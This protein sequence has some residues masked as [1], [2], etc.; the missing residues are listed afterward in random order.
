M[1][2]EEHKNLIDL[3]LASGGDAKKIQ[4]YQSFS[5]ANFV[6][7]KYFVKQLKVELPENTKLST[8]PTKLSTPHPE[9][10]APVKERKGI[11]NDLISQ[12]PV[13][14]HQE[15]QNRYKY[16]LEA[17]SLKVELN[18]VHY[19]DEKTAYEIQEKIMFCFEKMDKAQK[20][21][22]HYQKNKRIL[23]TETKVDFSGLSPM[24]L[25]N[26]RNVTRSNITKRK[27]TIKKMEDALPKSD[28]PDF[29]RKLHSVNL[30][31]EQLQMMINELEVLEKMVGN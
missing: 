31:I 1:T 20:A 29:K 10:S 6:K 23:K 14:L 22:N 7:L 30:K 24:E 28:H 15:Y 5:A 9:P 12:Y 3:Y 2:R 16:W 8:P 11:W 25:L 4:L 18:A 27:A 17:C 26:K 21:L 19:K 13:E